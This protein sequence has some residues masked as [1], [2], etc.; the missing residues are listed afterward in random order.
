VLDA[1]A[2]FHP[3]KAAGS[4][5]LVPQSSRADLP[6][7]IASG[8]AFVLKPS[9]RDPSASNFVA[10]LYAQAGMPAGVFNAGHGDKVAVA[11]DHPDIAAV[12][13]VRSTRLESIAL[14]RPSY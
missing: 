13:F 4:K 11:A 12:S 14:R 9:E 3:A 7:A 10:H 2:W 6:Y 8:N 5:F 1:C